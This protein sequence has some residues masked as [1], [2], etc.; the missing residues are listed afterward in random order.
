MPSCGASVSED[1]ASERKQFIAVCE[2]PNKN[3]YSTNY[4]CYS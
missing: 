3:T 4:S 2:T 1:A